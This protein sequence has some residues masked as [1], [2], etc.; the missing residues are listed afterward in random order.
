MTSIINEDALT[1]LPSMPAQSVDVVIT[2][3]RYNFGK[4]YPGV[5]DK[6]SMDDYFQEMRELGKGLLHVI[7]EG[8]V[9]F[10]NV[11]CRAANP[12]HDVNVAQCFLD[13]GWV[14]QERI[15][16][17]KADEEGNGHFTPINSNVYLNN[18]WESIFLFSKK[19]R[20]GL[21]RLAIGVPY[22][23]QTNITRWK[24]G[25]TVHCRGDI[26][27]IHYETIQ[28]RDKDRAGHEATFPRELVIRCL[29]LME[30]GRTGLTIL[31]PCCGIGTVPCVAEEQ[32]H[33]GIGIEL[34]PCIALAARTNLQISQSCP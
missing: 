13:V 12:L 31:D 23:D 24:S 10:L 34:S 5:S 3:P 9:V 2:S 33:I 1:Y 8:G 21:D 28:S 4:N 6:T 7:K 27:K 26:W 16:W 18:L 15:I 25:K 30:K 11:G 29:R 14:L 20:V 17:Q 22:K 19:G 32:G